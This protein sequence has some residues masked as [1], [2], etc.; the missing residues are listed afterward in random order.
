MIQISLVAF[1][2][3]ISDDKDQKL[4]QK[5]LLELE[6]IDDDCDQNDIAFVKI[7]DDHEAAEWG[8]DEIPTIVSVVIY[9][10]C[11]VCTSN[12]MRIIIALLSGF[13]LFSYTF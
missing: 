4:S 3:I 6:N 12:G 7:D 13:L 8:I 10:M 1:L 9:V 2:Y 11:S 5:V